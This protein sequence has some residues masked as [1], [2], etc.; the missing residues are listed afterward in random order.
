MVEAK[1]AIEFTDELAEFPIWRASCPCLLSS[2]F[3][4]TLS[5]RIVG[6]DRLTLKLDGARNT[7]I[8]TGSGREVHN[9]LRPVWLLVFP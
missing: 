9:T 1:V 3:R 6:R 2:L 5:S 7:R 4:D 8:W